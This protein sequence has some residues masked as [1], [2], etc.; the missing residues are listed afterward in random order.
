VTAYKATV[1]VTDTY[2]IDID[3]DSYVEAVAIAGFWDVSN[4]TSVAQAFD[5]EEVVAVADF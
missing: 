1:N 2:Y 5:V 4:E 3:A